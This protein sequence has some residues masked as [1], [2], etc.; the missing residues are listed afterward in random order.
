MSEPPTHT[1]P[2]L[3]HFGAQ[4][5]SHL[6][7][8]LA[9]ILRSGVPLL[10]ALS[11]LDTGANS[12][13][14][15]YIVRRLHRDIADGKS[16][17]V[18]LSSCGVFGPFP[19]TIV[20]IGESSSSLQQSLEYLAD[21]LKKKQALKKKMIGALL[22]PL[23]IICATFGISTALTTYIFPKILPVFKSFKHQL[24]LSTRILIALSDFLL[25]DGLLL[26]VALVVI[27][28]IAVFVL[29]IERV[30]AV[31]DAFVLRLPVLGTLTRAYNL[32]NLSR[33]LGLLLRTETGI[34]HA[35]E[36]TAESMGNLAYRRV[37][38]EMAQYAARGERISAAM[39]KSGL[40][41][42]LYG[43]MLRAGEETGNLAVSFSYLSEVYEEEINDLSRNLT[44]LLE[45][46]L[47]LVMGVIVGFIAISIIAPVYGITQ[48][49][50]PH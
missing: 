1:K 40:F 32:A 50:T 4:E 10:S 17:S 15:S 33:T 12:R 31:R 28:I 23:I 45:P 47:M 7:K 26:L 46:I 25:H 24:P 37:L 42:P 27:S 5:Q 11:M 38:L 49:L 9:M 29:R 39:E 43:Q 30:A 13:S 41:P 3:L 34:V 44:T 20:K 8:R 18:A 16:L 2:R 36:I 14:G 21:E 35:L 22:Y 48:N 6:A 19:V